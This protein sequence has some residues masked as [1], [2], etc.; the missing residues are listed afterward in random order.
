MTDH[1]PPELRE[2]VRA[3]VEDVAPAGEVAAIE[4]QIMEALEGRRTQ[5]PAQV[6]A[7]THEMVSERIR[8]T[9]EA[10]AA[11]LVDRG[12]LSPVVAAHIV[13]VPVDVVVGAQ[14]ASEEP[15]EEPAPEDPASGEPAPEE[16]A[17]GVIIEGWDDFWT[18]SGTA[19]GETS[20]ETPDETPDDVPAAQPPA[21]EAPDGA[22]PSAARPSSVFETWTGGASR[23]T[24]SRRSGLSVGAVGI[25]VVLLAIIGV[26]MLGDDGGEP[27]AVGE[28]TDIV[29][30][31]TDAPTDRATGADATD[32]PTGADAT[33][34]P[35]DQGTD[36]GAGDGVSLGGVEVAADGGGVA[37]AGR[38]ALLSMTVSGT[39]GRPA[40]LRWELRHDGDEVFPPAPLV[41]PADGDVRLA[42]PPALLAEAGD[43]LLRVSQD[44]T[45]L[46]ERGFEVVAG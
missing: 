14:D 37:Q 6:M 36:R 40:T 35:T 39:E 42:I 46:L 7:I 4:S 15:A 33:D 44:G 20:D 45:V 13:G 11:A 34:A 19:P 31:T 10:A 22:P 16:P 26:A 12:G 24:S 2:R 17:E 41:V 5:Q 25:G 23:Q 9:P 3:Y 28:P 32:D 1:L 38:S 8:I 43:Y 30:N 21:R 29:T 18:P 27:V